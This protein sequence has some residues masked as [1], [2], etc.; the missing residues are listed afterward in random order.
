MPDPLVNAP[1]GGIQGAPDLNCATRFEQNPFLI[2]PSLWYILLRL[3]SA[4]E[5]L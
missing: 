5:L 2:T 1:P 4:V 3:Y